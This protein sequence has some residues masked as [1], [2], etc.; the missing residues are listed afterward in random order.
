MTFPSLSGPARRSLRSKRRRDPRQHK[1]REKHPRTSLPVVI[2]SG[3][4]PFPFRTRKLSLIPPM[5]LHGK[6]CGRVGRCRHYLPSRARGF[7]RAL[8]LYAGSDLLPERAPAAPSPL[9]PAMRYPPRFVSGVRDITARRDYSVG[10]SSRK[11]LC[12]C[13]LTM[14][15]ASPAPK[16]GPGGTAGSSGRVSGAAPRGCGSWR[17]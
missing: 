13:P 15:H 2:G 12:R 4:H 1:S 10:P 6:L 14:R 17:R 5:V 3:S 9:R 7:P 16:T 11:A 8:F